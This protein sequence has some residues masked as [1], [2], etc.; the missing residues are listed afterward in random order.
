LSHLEALSAGQGIGL[1]LDLEPEGLLLKKF[2][3]ELYNN[4]Y[5]LLKLGAP[6]E[7][8]SMSIDEYKEAKA[9][10]KRR[11]RLLDEACGKVEAST[12]RPRGPK[13]KPNPGLNWKAS[14]IYQTKREVG[15][16]ASPTSV[17]NDLELLWEEIQAGLTLIEEMSC[18]GEE[19]LD[20]PADPTLKGSN[21]TLKRST[22]D[23][24]LN[25]GD[26]VD[27]EEVTLHVHVSVEDDTTPVEEA[28]VG[29]SAVEE[30][31]AAKEAPAA[32]EAP[33]A[34]AAAAEEKAPGPR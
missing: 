27:Q 16:S 18:D 15:E 26:Q 31:P 3:S 10:A 23:Q 17:L 20:S 33:D 9:K 7:K 8:A 28:P 12:I 21:V 29:A 1:Q 34:P 4:Q 30:T 25:A 32:E 2:N 14:A 22:T 6:A 19:L 24:L 11:V 5:L 13:P